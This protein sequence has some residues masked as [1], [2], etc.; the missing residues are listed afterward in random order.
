V[1]IHGGSLQTCGVTHAEGRRAGPRRRGPAG[2]GASVVLLAT[3]STGHEQVATGRRCQGG[4]RPPLPP[5]RPGPG[6]AAAG[7]GGKVP[8]LLPDSRL[9]AC[10]CRARRGARMHRRHARGLPNFLPARSAAMASATGFPL[11]RTAPATATK[12]QA[13][14]R[15]ACLPPAG[16]CARSAWERRRTGAAA[17][18][19]PRVVSLVASRCFRGGARSESSRAAP[20]VPVPRRGRSWRGRVALRILSPTHWSSV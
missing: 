9:S 1:A 2:G 3:C 11:A 7:K 12:R 17:G 8:Q 19:A 16:A 4:E 6:T 14:R 20:P 15:P 13:S 5:R 18:R 10:H